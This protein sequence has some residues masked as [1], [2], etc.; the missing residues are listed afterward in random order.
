QAIQAGNEIASQN[1]QQLQKLRD[2]IATQINMQGNY[3]AQEQDRIQLDDALRQQ[4]RSG[5]ITQTGS[6]KGY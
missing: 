3:M 6:N 4:R 1:V 5:T 2:L